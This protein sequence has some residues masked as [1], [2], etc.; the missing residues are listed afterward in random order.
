MWMLRIVPIFRSLFHS[1]GEPYKRPAVDL[2]RRARLRDELLH[3]S[4][5]YLEHPHEFRSDLGRY[6]HR[7]A[8]YLYQE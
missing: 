2:R 8:E 3:D 1:C 5:V 6:L 7:V 4:L